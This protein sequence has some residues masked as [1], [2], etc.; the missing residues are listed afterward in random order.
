MQSQYST[1]KHL[2]PGFETYTPSLKLQA[3]ADLDEETFLAEVKK[4]RAQKMSRLSRI[5]KFAPFGL[6]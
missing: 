1:K 5:W 3:R 2:L 4:L 6:A